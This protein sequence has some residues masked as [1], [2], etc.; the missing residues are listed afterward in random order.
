VGA[1]ADGAEAIGIFSAVS[2]FGRNDCVFSNVI[3]FIGVD[4][5][6]DW[7]V[8]I[9]IEALG[10]SWKFLIILSLS[11]IFF[12]WVAI[13]HCWKAAFVNSILNS[14][15]KIVAFFIACVCMAVLLTV[16]A[17]LLWGILSSIDVAFTA[18][19]QC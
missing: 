10:D 12:I 4:L 5:I 2:C 7:R 15:G 14:P 16:A 19:F 3:E 11:S 6:A 1:N 8:G 17:I 9:K 18:I 13:F